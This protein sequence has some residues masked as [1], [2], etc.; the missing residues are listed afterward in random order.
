MQPSIR[1]PLYDTYWTFA[2]ERQAIFHRRVR[3]EPWPWTEDP[4]L[5][6]FKFCNAYRASDRVSQY[7]IQRVIN[8]P[9]AR[10]LPAEDVFLRVILFRL[11]S[12]EQTWEA[13]EEKAG[14]VRIATFDTQGFGDLLEELRR[15]HPIYTAA[16]ILS[17]QDVYGRRA[18]HRNHLALVEHMFRPG[19][20]GSQLAR[21]R[22][23]ENV[24][25]AL[26]VWP[27]IGPFLAYQLSIDLNYTDHLSF[28]ED[29][30]TAPGPGALRGLKKVF[31]DPGSLKPRQ[32]IMRIVDRQE[33][34]FERLGI[35]FQDLF[36]RRLHAIDCQGLFCEVDKYAR[37]A[38]PDLKSNRV[39]IKQEFR[40]T[41]QPLR[42]F[43]PPKW[44]IN[45]RLHRELGVVSD[46]SG[47][48]QLHV[49]AGEQLT[50]LPNTV[51]LSLS[52]ERIATAES[53]SPE[54]Q[55]KG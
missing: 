21:A 51:A 26:L 45:D 31:R 49:R 3:G 22:S 36:G 14:G 33:E 5:R 48:S 42:L 2:S 27:M 40:P 52:Q 24:Y 7:L 50:I 16:F 25:Q 35:R 23:L 15:Q 47:T 10:D 12:K 17:G 20:L 6:R 46:T 8:E 37:E 4:I 18:K 34:E 11:F 29:D 30:F 38:F 53:V 54:E 44:G 32:L 1:P 13:L 41:G 19:G 39:R 9:W 43:Y 28:S 55:L